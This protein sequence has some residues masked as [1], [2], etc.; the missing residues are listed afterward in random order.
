MKW[1]VLGNQGAYP[2]PGGATAGHLL[3]HGQQQLMIDCGSGVIANLQ[4][5][6]ELQ[7]LSAVILTHLHADHSCELPVLRHALLS[8]KARGLWKTEKLDVYMPF[9][10]EAEYRFLQHMQDVFNFHEIEERTCLMNGQLAISCYTMNHPVPCFGLRIRGGNN[11]VICYT[12]DTN[13]F[14]DIADFCRNAD[15]LIADAFCLHEKWNEGLPHLS[16]K[17]CGEV[18][19]KAH[20]SRMLLT[21]FAPDA[22]P[23]ALLK[24]AS[25]AFGYAELS[26]INQAYDVG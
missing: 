23:D 12:S 13:M 18:A 7:A 11:K 6:I 5:H 2:L 14:D 22:N 26:V 4:K 10:P 17:L 1:T 16:A 19:T 3:S 24:E 20:A 8:L 9:A 21:H 25:R 15:L